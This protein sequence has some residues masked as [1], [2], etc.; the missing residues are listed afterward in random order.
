MRVRAVLRVA[1][2]RDV[3]RS[4][5]RVAEELGQVARPYLVAPETWTEQHLAVP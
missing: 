5:D 2:R 1:G 4:A 3:H